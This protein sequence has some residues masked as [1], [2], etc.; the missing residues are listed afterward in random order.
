MLDAPQPH[1]AKRR[2]Q[3]SAYDRYKQD[4]VSDARVAGSASLGSM[5]GS[6]RAP[7]SDDRVASIVVY[8]IKT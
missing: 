8:I 6:I 3:M 5:L 4:M 1:P 7:R 2:K